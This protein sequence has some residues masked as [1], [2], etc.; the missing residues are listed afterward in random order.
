VDS[1]GFKRG[2]SPLLHMVKVLFI[3]VHNA[4]RSQ[5]AEAI[6]NSLARG[7][8]QATSAG[9]QP[10][11]QVNP[12]VVQALKEIG[13]DISRSKPKKLTAD[14]LLLVDLAVTMGCGPDICP[15]VVGA[16]REWEIADPHGKSIEEIRV[17]RDDIL[18]RVKVLLNELD[19]H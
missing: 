9:S 15:V 13:I 14:M 18:L 11:S 1:V 8:H 19:S 16:I 17:I 6:F 7:R 5:M 10:A 2:A 12:A 4:G 3:C